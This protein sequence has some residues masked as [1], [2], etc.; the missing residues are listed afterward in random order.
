MRGLETRVV[1]LERTIRPG[2]AGVFMLWGRDEAEASRAVAEACERGEVCKRDLVF[3]A[4]WPHAGDL[5]PSRWIIYERLSDR[6]LEA[7]LTILKR[8]VGFSEE[9]C[10]PCRHDP[11]L[12]HMSTDEL[13]QAIARPCEIGEH[14]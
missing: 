10:G 7:F 6:E 11:E 4:I 1:R 2:A 12:L 3:P 5:P 9:A 14:K 8:L 13:F